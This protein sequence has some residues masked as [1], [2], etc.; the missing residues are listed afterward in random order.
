MKANQLKWGSTLSYLQMALNIIIGLCYTPVMIRLLGSSEYGLYNTVSS[1]ISILSVL[2]LGFGSGYIKYYAKYKA[3]DDRE[4]IFRLNG[5]FLV[6]FSII[7]LIALLCG[8]FLSGN[9]HLV[10]DEGLTD[11]E[12]K[13]ARVLMLLLTVNL[14]VSFPASVFSHI[15]SAHERYIFLKLLGAVRTVLS[16]LI[17]LPLL[18][19]GFRSIAMVAVS[20]VLHVAVDAIYFFYVIFV[21]KDRFIFGRVDKALFSSLFA[22]TAFIA[23]NMIVDQVNTNF[24]KIILGRYKGTTAV[25]VYSVG[26]TLYSFYLMFSNSISTVFTPRIHKIVIETSDRE[27]RQR[28][29][30]LFTTVG[31]IQFLVLALVSSGLVFFGKVFITRYWAGSL[32]SDAYFVALLLIIPSTIPLIQNLGIEIQRAQNKHRFRSLAYAVMAVVNLGLSVI[33]CQKYGAVGAAV[34][35]AFSLILANGIIINIYYHKQCCIDILAFWKS[36][37]SMLP[38]LVP[39]AVLGVALNAFV[40]YNSFVKFALCILL[41]AAVYC[42][43]MWFISMN[44]YEKS[45]IITPANKILGKLRHKK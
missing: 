32:Y 6:I 12:Y 33:L 8:L 41:Y 38:G 5:L 35:T 9:L 39:C 25:S 37:V 24:G 4:S 21:I 40:K 22:Y 3:E 27:R 23:I 34:G 13:I 10:F 31:R 2:S 29:T 20:V 45:L 26:Y 30:D 43:S 28:L 1:T 7:G 16:P 44:E 11:G 14:A 19:M 15:I 17:T 36:I 42:L 18:L